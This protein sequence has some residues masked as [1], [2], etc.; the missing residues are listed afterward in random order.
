MRAA[1][2]GVYQNDF[3]MSLG[4]LALFLVPFLLLGLVL[5]KPLARF[6]HF[7]ESKVEASKLME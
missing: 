7:Y 4:C 6:M 2:M 5:R 1:M 3:W